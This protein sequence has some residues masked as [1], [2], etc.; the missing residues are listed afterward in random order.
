[1]CQ[2]VKWRYKGLGQTSTDS[3][4][5]YGTSNGVLNTTFRNA[6][7]TFAYDKIQDLN[8]QSENGSVMVMSK[9]KNSHRWYGCCL[10]TQLK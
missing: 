8:E 3:N 6:D 10:L 1:M 2:S 5:W 4:N 7:G 9:S